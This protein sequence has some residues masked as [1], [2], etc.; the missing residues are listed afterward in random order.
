MFIHPLNPDNGSKHHLK[1]LSS[2]R[3]SQVDNY[4]GD[5]Q[6]VVGEYFDRKFTLVKVK[7]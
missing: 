7:M 5:S 3:Y 4:A 2:Y 6:L 1:C